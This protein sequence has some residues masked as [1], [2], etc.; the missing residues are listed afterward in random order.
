M[1]TFIL[2][3]EVSE[4]GSVVGVVERA[5]TGEKE[6]FQGYEMLAD[7]LRQMV[8]S[9]DRMPGRRINAQEARL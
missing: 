8:D 2:R 7:V 9:D 3:L 4:I 6:R 1:K 5:R